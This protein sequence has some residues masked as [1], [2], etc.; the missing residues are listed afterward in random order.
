MKILYLFIF[1]L[2]ISCCTSNDEHFTSDK[3]EHFTYDG[4][5]YL[6]FRVIHTDKCLRAPA[7]C[8]HSPNCK[9]C[10]LMYD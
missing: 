2:L 5:D 8:V 1:S 10:F 4:H 6:Y 3:V 9:K 7:S